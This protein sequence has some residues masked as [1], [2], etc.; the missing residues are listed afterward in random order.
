M[1]P[2]IPA[3]LAELAEMIKTAEKFRLLAGGTDYMV[4]HGRTA[5]DRPVIDLSGIA[6][7]HGI[8]FSENEIVIGA[9]ETM[10]ALSAHAGLRPKAACLCEAASRVGSW[11]IRNRATV[12]GNMANAS[13]AADTPAALAALDAK[14]RLVSSRGARMAAAGDIPI[15]PNRA[16]IEPDEIIVSFHLP[17]KPGRISAFGK[18]G[19]R[20]QVSI[21]RLNLAV[22]AVLEGGRVIEARVFMGTLGAAA[23]HCPEAEKVLVEKGLEAEEQFGGALAHAAAEAIPGR[24]TLAYKQSGARALAEDVLTGLRAEAMKGRL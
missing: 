19:S 11:Q 14:A 10:S 3:T 24:S 13:P 22:S 21:A 6:E 9:M 7:L 17:I 18:I 2:M 23:L 15:G 4:A 12:G 16:A 20:T 1:E 8:T 5:P